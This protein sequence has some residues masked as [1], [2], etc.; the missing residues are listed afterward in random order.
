MEKRGLTKTN[1]IFLTGKQFDIKLPIGHISQKEM[2]NRSFLF[3]IPKKKT[4]SF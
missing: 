1:I 2:Q 4:D 3:E